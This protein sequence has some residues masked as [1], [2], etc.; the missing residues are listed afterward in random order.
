MV[1]EDGLRPYFLLGAKDRVLRVGKGTKVQWNRLMCTGTCI[2]KSL[3]TCL[4]K[5]NKRESFEAAYRATYNAT[6]SKLE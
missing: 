2:C 1:P 3:I 4:I 5:V 6:E